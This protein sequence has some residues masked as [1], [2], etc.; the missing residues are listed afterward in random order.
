MNGVLIGKGADEAG[1]LRRQAQL[2]C[3][4]GASNLSGAYDYCCKHT[5]PYW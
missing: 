1:L 4:V 2:A 3:L 5:R